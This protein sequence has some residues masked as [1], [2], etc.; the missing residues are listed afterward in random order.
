MISFLADLRGAY[1]LGGD[2]LLFPVKCGD[3]PTLRFGGGRMFGMVSEGFLSFSLHSVAL[4]LRYYGT[5]DSLFSDYSGYLAVRFGRVG[6]SASYG[7]NSVGSSRSTY[8]GAMVSFEGRA[9][10]VILRVS[11]GY[12]ITPILAAEGDLRRADSGIRVVAVS[13]PGIYVDVAVLPYIHVG[14]ISIGGLYRTSGNTFG[15]F[16]SYR[17]TLGLLS[18][19]FSTHEALGEGVLSDNLLVL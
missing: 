6:V 9:S 1:P 17:H 10:P 12:V 5:G 18:L 14:Q 2:N 15:L 7:S 13:R 16:L 11:A 8:G 19:L 4:G 3:L